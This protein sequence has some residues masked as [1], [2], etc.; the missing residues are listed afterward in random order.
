MASFP[1]NA[2]SALSIVQVAVNSVATPIKQLFTGD[3]Y[4]PSNWSTG[5]SLYS[6]VIPASSQTQLTPTPISNGNQTN[7]FNF[8][9]LFIGDTIYVFDATFVAKHSRR[10]RATERPIQSGFNVADS[11]VLQQPIVTL[12]IGMSDTMDEF[13]AGMWQGN[14]SKSISAFDTL[15]RLMDDRV[16]LTLNT[17]LKSYQNMLL[18]NVDPTEDKKSRFGLRATLTFK[19]MLLVTVASTTLSARPN[20]TGSTQLG[21]QQGSSVP[22]AITNNNSLPSSVN[23]SLNVDTLTNQFGTVANAG[24]FSSNPTQTIP[25]T[26][27][28]N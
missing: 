22:A 10:L 4:R 16:L 1:I 23:P 27:G 8:Q 19:Q 13:T 26:L 28:S 24:V 14:Q 12:E 18:I 11:A 21:T 15:V 17:W 2:S 9:T 6:I 25:S 7:T 3:S 20:A 5:H